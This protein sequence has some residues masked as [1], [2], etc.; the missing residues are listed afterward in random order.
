MCYVYL[1]REQGLMLTTGFTCHGHQEWQGHDDLQGVVRHRLTEELGR[2]ALG[3][4][5]LRLGL[6]RAAFFCGRRAFVAGGQVHLSRGRRLR[7][8]PEG[9]LL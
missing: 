8:G 3:S 1:P 4:V 5:L 9:P 6:V 2:D 7:P